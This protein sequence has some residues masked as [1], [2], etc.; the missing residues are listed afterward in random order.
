[1]GNP[2]KLTL[3]NVYQ[4]HVKMEEHVFMELSLLLVSVLL[5]LMGY[6][7]KLT[8]TV[9]YLTLVRMEEAVWMD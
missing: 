8:M 7:M 5:D 4:I 9:A 1:M 3:M 2:A 6:P